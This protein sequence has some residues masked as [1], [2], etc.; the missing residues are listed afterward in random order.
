MSEYEDHFMQIWRL[1]KVMEH[2]GLGRST[3]YKM[4]GEGTFPKSVPLGERSVGWVAQE[5]EDWIRARIN[6][7]NTSSPLSKLIQPPVC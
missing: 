4:V 7:R 2:T 5:V 3:L 1:K 6:A